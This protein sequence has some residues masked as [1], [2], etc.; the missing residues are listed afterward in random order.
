MPE[1]LLNDSEGS[2]PPDDASGSEQRR[3][4]FADLMG[5]RPIPRAVSLTDLVA[6]I[7]GFAG[8]AYIYRGTVLV[9]HNLDASGRLLVAMV[10]FLW[11]GTVLAGPLVLFL[12]NIQ[13]A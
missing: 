13:H 5:R 2:R 4:M 10:A 8:A 6:L 9:E 7:I 11:L 3:S 1:R 12:R